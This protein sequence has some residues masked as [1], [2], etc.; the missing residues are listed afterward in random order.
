MP[1]DTY[2]LV[3]THGQLLIVLKVIEAACQAWAAI[4]VATPEEVETLLKTLTE[5]ERD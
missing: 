1:A 3:L 2:S 4:N 5:V